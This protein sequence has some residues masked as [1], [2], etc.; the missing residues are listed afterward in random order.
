M[1]LISVLVINGTSW[2]TII[3]ASSLSSVTI[4]GVDRI[5]AFPDPAKAL[6]IA[7]KPLLVVELKDPV[8]MLPPLLTAPAR[9]EILSP[10]AAAS[11][12]GI[13]PLKLIIPR[14][15]SPLESH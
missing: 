13:V 5:L 7:P 3:I 4:E 14:P 8:A 10:L 9:L 12:A 2:P 15:L 6:R 1:D 11:N